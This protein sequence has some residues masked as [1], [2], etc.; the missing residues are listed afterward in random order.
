MNLGQ[1]LKEHYLR[2]KWWRWDFCRVHGLT[3]CNK[4]CICESQSPECRT[5]SLRNWEIP[6]ILVWSCAGMPHERLAGQVLLAKPIG[7]L[8]SS[9]PRT[10]WSDYIS[11][12]AWSH[13]GVEPAEISEIAFD[14]EVFWVLR[15]LTP[16]LSLEEN[17]HENQWNLCF[18]EK[19][20]K[21]HCRPDVTQMS[22]STTSERV[23][24]ESR[25]TEVFYFIT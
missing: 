13:L 16:R 5:T 1:W 23:I 8:P 3:L 19:K 22:G 20:M 15:L 4:V 6:A 21:V 10:R 12:P 7:E 18:V 25:Y 2:D 17:R 11:D 9:R 24:S 14:N